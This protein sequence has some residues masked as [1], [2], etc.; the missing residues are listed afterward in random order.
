M[1]HTNQKLL[2]RLSMP[3]KDLNEAIELMHESGKELVS[4]YQRL[5]SMSDHIERLQDQVERLSLDLGMREMG[6]H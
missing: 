1:V 2:I 4:L 3:P 6:K 5:L